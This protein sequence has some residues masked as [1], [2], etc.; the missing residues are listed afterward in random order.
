MRTIGEAVNKINSVVRNI[1]NVRTTQK[2]NS[3]KDVRVM[4]AH[5]DYDE[6]CVKRYGGIKWVFNQWRNLLKNDNNAMDKICSE[7]I[8]IL[9]FES[10]EQ[11][12][13]NGDSK[14]M[15]RQKMLGKIRILLNLETVTYLQT[16]PKQLEDIQRAVENLSEISFLS[17][18]TNI[19]QI[20]QCLREMNFYQVLNSYLHDLSHKCD[21]SS[22]KTFESIRNK[23]PSDLENELSGLLDKFQ[24]ELEGFSASSAAESW[25]M[26]DAYICLNKKV[27]EGWF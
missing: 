4:L 22:L 18:D 19:E 12:C 1:E 7:K 17:D 16:P 8:C 15:K 24:T 5:W 23:L 2:L 11:I 21:D 26:N 10:D 9:S 3:C 14:D 13:Q 6:A 27:Q 25:I 20:E